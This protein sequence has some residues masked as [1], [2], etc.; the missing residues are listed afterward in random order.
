VK[1]LSENVDH[2]LGWDL[3]IGDVTGDGYDDVLITDIKTWK[4]EIEGGGGG[5]GKSSEH[6]AQP[7][8]EA[9]DSQVYINGPNNN[10]GTYSRLMTNYGVTTR[11]FYQPDLSMLPEN[12]EIEEAIISFWHSYNANSG[13]NLEVRNVEE[14]WLE[15]KI[16]WNNQPKVSSESV[17]VTMQGSYEWLDFHIEEFAQIWVDDPEENYG[18][19]ISGVNGVYNSAYISSS[20]DYDSSNQ[21]PIRGFYGAH[22]SERMIYQ[23]RLNFMHVWGV[24]LFLCTIHDSALGNSQIFTGKALNK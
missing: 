13:Q 1:Y 4:K 2:K 9:K 18:V 21:E 15:D 16:T 20:D 8:S 19:R 23:R 5:G 17:E 10:Y 6:F 22:R 14:F 24:L 3:E 12:I 7:G 11:G